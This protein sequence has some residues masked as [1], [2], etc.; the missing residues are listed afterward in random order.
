MAGRGCRDR[1]TFYSITQTCKAYFTIWK[2]LNIWLTI[3]D[4]GFYITFEKKKEILSVTCLSNLSVN[5]SQWWKANYQETL[6]SSFIN[7][8]GKYKPYLPC[9]ITYSKKRSDICKL[10]LWFRCWKWNVTKTVSVLKTCDTVGV[11]FEGES[12]CHLLVD[13]HKSSC[14][15]DKCMWTIQCTARVNVHQNQWVS[16]M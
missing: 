11:E 4:L 14:S 8:H 12:I 9:S 6:H 5:Q 16:D 1:V 7:L 2:T 10:I 13:Y 15:I 3:L